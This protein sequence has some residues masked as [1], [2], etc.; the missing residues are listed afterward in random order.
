MEIERTFKLLQNQRMQRG[1]KGRLLKMEIES[2]FLFL[3]CLN[4]KFR[5]K[6]RLLKMEIESSIHSLNTSSP[7]SKKGRLLKMEIE[8]CC[9]CYVPYVCSV[10]K[11]GS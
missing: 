7:P 2:F 8:S 10:R 6:G 1:K 9:V 4:T 11:G 5:K 3:F